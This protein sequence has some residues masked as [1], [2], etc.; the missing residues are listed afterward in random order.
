MRA[1]ALRLGAALSVA[2]AVLL[3]VAWLRGPEYDEGY[4]L[5]LAAGHRL[6]DWP[7]GAFRAGEVRALYAGV[8]SP[9]EIAAALRAQDVHPPLYF[10]L[11]AAWRWAA[12]DAWFAARLL[13]VLLSLGALGL[14]AAIARRLR[15]P[16]ATSV[17]LTVGC[18]GIAYTGAIARGF[19]L[20]QVLG[21]AGVYLAMRARDAERAALAGAAGVAL[22]LASFANYLAA[23]T[24]AAVVL[25][26]VRRPRLALAAATGMALSLP[27]DLYFFLA[28]R[29]ARPDQFPPFDPLAALWRLAHYQ[30]AAVFGGLP[31]YV[32]AAAAPAV[33]ALVIGFVALLCVLVWQRRA[34]IATPQA[35]ALLTLLSVAPVAGLLALGALAGTAPVELRYLAFGLPSIALLLAGALRGRR[36]ALA[37]VLG[38][39]AA[40]IAGL[41]LRPETMQ[42][43]GAAALEAA[44]GGDTETLVLVPR[45]ND[46]VGVV[47][48]F[49]AMAPDALRLR[50]IAAGTSLPDIRAAAAG[51]RRVE[52]ARLGLDADSRAVLPAITAALDTPCWR[53]DMRD[54]VVVTWE[55][56]CGGD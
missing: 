12:G 29:G 56:V 15:L 2:L 24:G 38:M 14:C 17:L 42:P 19:A 7:R 34:T 52:L 28:Q 32:G 43:Q 20:A 49:V 13:S 21:L 35:R 30:V 25:W 45:G 48:A 1:E 44:A 54:R 18:Y 10:W 8:A 41:M 50:V 37:A 39:Q 16:A 23:F 4:T 22:G 27:G 6:P 36:V 53:E 33:A 31:L 47:G 51:A 3:G 9:G 26:L 40:S 46:G 55:R 5:F 11:Y